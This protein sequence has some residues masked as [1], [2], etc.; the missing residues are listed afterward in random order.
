MGTRDGRPYS[1]PM[2]A[3]TEAD[4][5]A[6]RTSRYAPAFFARD[7]MPLVQAFEGRLAVVALELSD[8]ILH[9]LH[10]GR[11]IRERVLNRVPIHFPRYA[12][13]QRHFEIVVT[14]FQVAPIEPASCRLTNS[15]RATH[16]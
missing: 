10:V 5:L 12:F 14:S 6:A 16:Q 15:H 13:N 3:L 11:S 8:S 4:V 2:I 7:A 9:C 1:E